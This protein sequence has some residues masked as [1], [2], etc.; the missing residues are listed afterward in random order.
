MVFGGPRRAVFTNGAPF[1]LTRIEASQLVGAQAQ[2]ALGAGI[3]RADRSAGIVHHDS[4]T[5]RV[6]DRTQLIVPVTKKRCSANPIGDIVDEEMKRG[7]TVEDGGTGHDLYLAACAARHAVLM[8][9]E[10]RAGIWDEH[11]AICTAIRAG[12]GALAA[13]LS[14]GHADSARQS[15]VRSLEMSLQHPPHAA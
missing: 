14:E 9:G 8:H 13:T 10:S 3:V 11:E 1:V 6:D 5:H 2:Y 7:P 15:L 12:D 4:F